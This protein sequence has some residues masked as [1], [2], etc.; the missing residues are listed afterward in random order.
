VPP[1]SGNYLG[2]FVIEIHRHL[3]GERKDRAATKSFVGRM[4]LL[5]R[6]KENQK[7]GGRQ[8]AK[9]VLTVARSS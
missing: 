6:A 8:T 7:I 4:E 3:S 9:G 2:K 1:T 5:P